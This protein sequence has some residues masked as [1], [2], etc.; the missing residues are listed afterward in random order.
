MERKEESLVGLAA[1]INSLVSLC[2]RPTIEQAGI[3]PA[4]YEL[5]SAVKRADGKVSQ[6]EIGRR[7]G[8]SRATVSEAISICEDKGW[9]ERRPSYIDGRAN[10]LIITAAGEKVIRPILQH[11]VELE[12]MA[13]I[14]ISPK[15]REVAIRGLGSAAAQLEYLLEMRT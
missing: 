12:A 7:L 11:Q 5:L 2:L 4:Q 9:L 10:V 3:T 15:A 8:V 14:R 6:S 13:L 1:K